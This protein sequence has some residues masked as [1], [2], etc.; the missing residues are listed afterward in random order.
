MGKLLT[1][2]RADGRSLVL[3]DSS[4]TPG[5]IGWF[6]LTESLEQATLTCGGDLGTGMLGGEPRWWGAE[7]PSGEAEARVPG[8]PS[9]ELSPQNTCT[10]AVG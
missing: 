5:D 9:P 1:P 4:Q 3:G 2:Q 10:S 6:L 8:V 7:G